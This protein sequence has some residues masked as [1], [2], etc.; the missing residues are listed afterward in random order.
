MRE[1]VGHAPRALL[2]I[3]HNAH[4]SLLF[5]AFDCHIWLYKMAPNPCRAH[6]P[7]AHRPEDYGARRRGH[8]LGEGRCGRRY[9]TERC[10]RVGRSEQRSRKGSERI[11]QSKRCSADCARGDAGGEGEEKKW[12]ERLAEEQSDAVESHQAE[13]RRRERGKTR[14]LRRYRLR[15][16]EGGKGSDRLLLLTPRLLQLTQQALVA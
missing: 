14:A 9:G 8:A 16:L 12:D 6:T 11:P 15:A 1:S 4:R 3:V 7:T 2:S 10:P 13:G 5:T